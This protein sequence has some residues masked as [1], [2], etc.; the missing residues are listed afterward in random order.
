MTLKKPSVDT[1]TYLKYPVEEVDTGDNANPVAKQPKRP[2]GRPKH[3][4]KA[5][6]EIRRKEELARETLHHMQQMNARDSARRTTAAQSI[7]RT[8]DQQHN[9]ERSDTEDFPG[10]NDVRG[11]SA[12]LE[13]GD[14]A[15]EILSSS[16]DEN[17]FTE[18]KEKLL[19]QLKRLDEKAGRVR[20]KREVPA[21]LGSLPSARAGSSRSLGSR[22]FGYWQ[23]SDMHQMLAR[24][25]RR[26]SA[27]GFVSFAAAA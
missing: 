8:Y 1:I 5:E 23:P 20:K 27:I 4:A 24:P 9:L 25:P 18:K 13:G 17:M 6:E 14:A 16:D 2:V 11:S 15:T 12:E 21:I 22:V 7:I 3:A 19:D 26:A 10:Y